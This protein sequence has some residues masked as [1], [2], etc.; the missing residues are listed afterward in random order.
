MLPFLRKEALSKKQSLRNEG[1]DINRLFFA[2]LTRS[3]TFDSA[4]QTMSGEVVGNVVA[5]C[6]Y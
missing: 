4:S 3:E 5:T 1:E 6:I 2:W